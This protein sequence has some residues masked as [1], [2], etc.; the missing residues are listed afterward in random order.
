M[1]VVSVSSVYETEPM[2]VEDQGWFLNCAAVVETDLSPAELLAFLKA[3]E[4]EVGREGGKPRNA[5]RE[6]DIDLLLY[7]DVT[8]SE[9]SL[10]VPHPRM[11]ER[12]FVLVPLAEVRP[13]LLHPVLKKTVTELL[14]ELET[15]KT[16]VRVPGALGD[17]SPPPPRRSSRPGRS[18]SRRGS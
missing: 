13:D 10:E 17:L 4:R 3:A 2:Y 6:I 5:P 9:P 8:V 16:V 1:R 11:G 15:D 14:S 18:P 7:G 12:A